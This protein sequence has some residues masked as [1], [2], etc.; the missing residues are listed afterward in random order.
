MKTYKIFDAMQSVADA[1][2]NA[3]TKCVET[4]SETKQKCMVKRLQSIDKEQ[5]WLRSQ[6]GHRLQTSTPAQV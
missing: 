2:K 6:L 4:I 1:A 3:A 5:E